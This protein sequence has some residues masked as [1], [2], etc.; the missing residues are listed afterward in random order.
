MEIYKNK[1]HLL[2]TILNNANSSRQAY[3]AYKVKQ[4]TAR[5]VVSTLLIL[6]ILIF[7]DVK[8]SRW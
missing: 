8:V 6:W 1:W 5:F 7:R 3:R 4:V 2:Y